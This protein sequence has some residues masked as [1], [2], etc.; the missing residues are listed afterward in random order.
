MFIL[1]LSGPGDVLKCGL[2]EAKNIQI[3]AHIK[4]GVLG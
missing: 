4:V 3:W 2:S 1:W